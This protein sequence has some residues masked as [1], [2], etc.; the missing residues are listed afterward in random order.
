MRKPSFTGLA[1]MVRK[2]VVLRS[3]E[4]M[5]SIPRPLKR[6]MQNEEQPADIAGEIF[7]ESDFTLLAKRPSDQP[8]RR[9]APG[10]NRPR[11]RR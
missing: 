4:W 8:L 1:R 7:L 11:A 5:N 6:P 9:D 2:P 3:V 10:S